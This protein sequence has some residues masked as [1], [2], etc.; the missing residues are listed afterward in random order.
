MEWPNWLWIGRTFTK[1][2]EEG[3]KQLAIG[4][5]GWVEWTMATA[6]IG[7]GNGHLAYSSSSFLNVLWKKMDGA[8]KDEGGG[9]IFCLLP[10]A[11][12][13]P[14]PNI[15]NPNGINLCS[16]AKLQLHF[17]RD[18]IHIFHVGIGLG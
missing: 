18:S 2:M 7:Q 13:F 3:P 8:E 6:D 16:K 4:A 12:S 11:A 15:W 17:V 9:C 10:A 5:R 14:V 1:K